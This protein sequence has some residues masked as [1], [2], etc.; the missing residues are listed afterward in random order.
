MHKLNKNSKF[1]EVLNTLKKEGYPT[2]RLIPEA[3]KMNLMLLDHRYYENDTQDILVAL[4]N[5]GN[6][7]KT[8][9][10]VVPY[11]V[12]IN[13][14]EALYVIEG[15]IFLISVNNNFFPGIE[16]IF[17]RSI[18][19]NNGH[20]KES[21]GLFKSTSGKIY[22]PTLKN[23]I[24]YIMEQ[25]YTY[26]LPKKILADPRNNNG[27][28]YPME[29]AVETLRDR[30]DIIRD[31]QCKMI[32]L[33]KNIIDHIDD[34]YDLDPYYSIQIRFNRNEYHAGRHALEFMGSFL[35]DLERSD[36]PL[37]ILAH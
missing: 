6:N 34:K 31:I 19:K 7:D 27:I 14:P 18:H 37:S 23:T 32:G 21:H 4:R 25:E 12:D 28:L 9:T 36:I 3:I 17:S 30:K 24:V 5:V 8:Y 35:F 22:T 20:T 10:I 16:I 13:D 1:V 26:T 11:D 33:D 15:A 29:V 2:D